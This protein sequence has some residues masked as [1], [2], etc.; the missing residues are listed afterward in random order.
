MTDMHLIETIALEL[1][2][3]TIDEDTRTSRNKS[4]TEPRACQPADPHGHEHIP[5]PIPEGD[6]NYQGTCSY[7][8]DRN[9]LH[10]V[11]SR[12]PGGRAQTRYK[13]KVCNVFLC[14]TT[15]ARKGS[16]SKPCL[17]EHR[18][19]VLNGSDRLLTRTRFDPTKP[20]GCKR[21]RRTPRS[22]S[23]G[24]GGSF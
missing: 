3:N 1:I 4:R 15:N 23:G 2:E 24:G 21:G 12:D 22:S 17:D 14:P 9:I 8:R 16:E 20:S 13:C 5:E 11:K 6:W 19:E 10:G 7:C 18:T